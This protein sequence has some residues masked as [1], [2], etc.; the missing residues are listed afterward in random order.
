MNKNRKSKWLILLVISIVFI[1]WIAWG[2]TA[3]E[4]NEYQIISENLPD[5]F[6]GFRIVHISDLHNAK[7]GE[8]NSK[9]LE[10]LANAEPDIIVITGDIIDSYHTDV[11]V[12]LKFVEKAVEIAP[13]YY[14]TGNHE[15]R[16]S[17]EIYLD[18]EEKMEGFGVVVLH[19][20][21]ISIEQEGKNISLGGIDDSLFASNHYDISY[22]NLSDYIE[23][24]FREDDFQILLSHRPE[25]FQDY[26]DAG[27]NLVFSGHAHGGQFRLPFVGGLV[28]PN[29]G[30]FPEYDAGLFSEDGTNMM[31]SRGI[32]NSI[33]PIRFNN[34]PEVIL[35][36]LSN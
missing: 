4:L 11:E 23:E 9:L 24:L 5:A 30:L 12:S 34:R 31:V 20:E 8:E 22:S 14:V 15:A 2:N 16:L 25:K 28:A 7:I 27:V 18:F 21:M 35:V 17:K 13:C 3:I 36:E 19:D 26:V 32:G 10:L 1:I 29:Q 6:Y 33:I